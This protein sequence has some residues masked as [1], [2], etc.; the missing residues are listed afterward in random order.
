MLGAIETLGQTKASETADLGK[1]RGSRLGS[2]S[3]RK[4]RVSSPNSA[5]LA[6]AMDAAVAYAVS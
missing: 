2:I 5:A 6:L 4:V 1:L 3:S